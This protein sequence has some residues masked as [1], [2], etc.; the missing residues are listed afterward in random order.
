MG[1]F[2]KKLLEELERSVLRI[3]PAFV[4][5]PVPPVSA[6]LVIF[7]KGAFGLAQYVRPECVAIK[8][9]GVVVIVGQSNA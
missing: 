6:T 5:T 8:K 1:E 2:G 3:K 7:V 9:R 4:G